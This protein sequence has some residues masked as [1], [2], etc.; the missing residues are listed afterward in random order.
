M[1]HTHSHKA[2]EV[3]HETVKETIKAVPKVDDK[4]KYTPDGLPDEEWP[5]VIIGVNEDGTV[6]LM[7]EPKKGQKEMKTQVALAQGTEK[8][9]E[10]FCVLA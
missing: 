1:S 9:K 7:V 3:T 4:V 5:G 6:D 10:R 8:P 2:H